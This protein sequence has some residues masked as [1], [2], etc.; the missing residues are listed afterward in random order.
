MM[1]YRFHS[2][3]ICIQTLSLL[4]NQKIRLKISLNLSV[5]TFA[6]CISVSH[7]D[8]FYTIDQT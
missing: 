4:N 5:L 1:W 2:W 7:I 8:K 6:M 3:V